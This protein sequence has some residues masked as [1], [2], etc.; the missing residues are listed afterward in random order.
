MSQF[1]QFLSQWGMVLAIGMVVL[2][3]ILAVVSNVM[4]SRGSGFDA[5]KGQILHFVEMIALVSAFF[6]FV[7][8]MGSQYIHQQQGGQAVGNI[9]QQACQQFMQGAGGT[10]QNVQQQSGICPS[11]SQ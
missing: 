8:F 9:L 6:A 4:Q 11:Q 5:L 1:V 3:G 10:D 7:G 2:A